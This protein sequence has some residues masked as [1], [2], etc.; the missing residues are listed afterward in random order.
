MSRGRLTREPP[1][2]RHAPA[3]QIWSNAVATELR[4]RIPRSGARDFEEQYAPTADG[5]AVALR[6]E[7]RDHFERCRS[8]NDGHAA[9]GQRYDDG[10][11]AAARPPPLEAGDVVDV[12]KEDGSGVV[13]CS[14]QGGDARAVLVK[15]PGGAQEEI[16]RSSWRL[17]G[18][19]R[20]RGAA[21]TSPSSRRRCSSRRSR[22][23][24][25]PPV[26]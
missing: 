5:R 16:P 19:A 2:L 8:A 9:A 6:G 3:L 17:G 23:C 24:G 1:A 11:A 10:A 18:A 4:V 25:N 13:E 12:S 26:S 22:L 21:R 7:W 20:G 14:V 15:P